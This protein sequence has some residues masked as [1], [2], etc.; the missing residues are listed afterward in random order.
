MHG[1][2]SFFL[3]A[4]IHEKTGSFAT[5]VLFDFRKTNSSWR[6]EGN[7]WIIILKCLPQDNWIEKS[8]LN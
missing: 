2:R 4:I 7:E 3:H 1:I 8:G 6:E 5:Q